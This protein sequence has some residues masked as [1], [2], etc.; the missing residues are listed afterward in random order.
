MPHFDL[1]IVGAGPGGMAAAT[2]SSLQGLKVAIVNAQKLWGYGI[3]GAYKSKG[4]YELA[5]DH[6][7]A[8][9]P[10]RG[11][12][13]AAPKVDMTQIQDQLQQGSYEL[14]SL[15][16]EQIG[17]LG[18][19]EIKGYGQFHDAHTVIVD[20][21]QYTGDKIII[22]T[23]T[24][25]RAIANVQ[26]NSERIMTSDEIVG[27]GELPES[28]LILG[29]GVIGCEFAS[30]FNAFG[31]K[32]ILL[33][34]KPSVLSHEDDDMAGFLTEN[35]KAND[36]TVH[37]SSRLANMVDVGDGVLTSLEDGTIFK[38]EIALISVGR[39]ACSAELQ[40]DRAGI[41]LDD[42]GYIKINA[43]CQ[44]NVDHIYAVGDV[45]RR[46]E[47]FALSLVHVAEAEGHQAVAHILGNE[48]PIPMDHIPFI[49]FTMP[50]IA[51]AG[52]N[53]KSAREKYGAVRVAK[54]NNVRNHRAHAMR[55][56]AGFVKLIVGPGGDDRILGVRSCGPQADSLIGEVS[57]C[58]QRGL[59]YTYLM[60]AIHAHPSLSESL[61]NA[62][63]MLAGLYPDH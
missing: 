13:P 50:L 25:P 12:L 1:L 35:F 21:K 43:Y 10:G 9:K 31:C 20:G 16:Q 15:Y 42:Q 6:M 56:F 7:V 26:S 29:A 44:T 63:R 58:I 24:K 33:D 37:H 57:L 32:V 36:I 48:Q 53:E 60:D 23:G 61:H 54:L 39:E 27:L 8:T 2:R 40:L 22:A 41:A 34:N 52:E 4:M 17:L 62:A 28:L 49:I 19:T 55:S 59:P 30:I 38:T 3:H 46:P 51:G 11:Y 47:D 18:I 14:E 5:K 45:S